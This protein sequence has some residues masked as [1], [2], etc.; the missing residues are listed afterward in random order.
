VGTDD[1]RTKGGQAAE[2]IYLKS[3]PNSAHVNGKNGLFVSRRINVS[4]HAGSSA[5]RNNPE[6]GFSG[7]GDE[8]GHFFL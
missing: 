6:A 8:F 3:G 5:V 7:Q 1:T 2:L 4:N